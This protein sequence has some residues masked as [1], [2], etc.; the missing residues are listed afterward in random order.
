MA[1]SR[2]HKPCVGGQ[3]VAVDTRPPHRLLRN[4]AIRT[5]QL[6][7]PVVYDARLLV[8]RSARAGGKGERRG[9][10]DAPVH[11]FFMYRGHCGRIPHQN[12]APPMSEVRAIQRSIARLR[13]FA[14]SSHG[15]CTGP[16]SPW[17]SAAAAASRQAG[18]T[19]G[20]N[21]RVMLPEARKLLNR[22]SALLE[23]EHLR[24]EDFE[25]LYIYRSLHCYVCCDRRR[26]RRFKAKSS[27]CRLP[28]TAP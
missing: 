18:D 24:R 19:S 7:Q 2:I 10:Q 16:A 28:D 8:H 23:D 4:F 5:P 11:L 13:R 1:Y 22:A 26:R 27:M 20:D 12:N 9:N 25:V 21:A 17:A 14:P 6:V 3:P 15:L